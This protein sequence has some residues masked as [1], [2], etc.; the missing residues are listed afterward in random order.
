MSMKKTT[1]REGRG[2]EASAVKE[3]KRRWSAVDTLVVLAL[4]LAVAGVIVRAVMNDREEAAQTYDGPFDV[5][6]TVPEI[7]ESVLSE[8]HGFDMLYL[9]ETGEKMGY[10]GKYDDGSVALTATGVLPVA[11]GETVSAQGCFVCLEGTL[12]DGG[13][14]P[15]GAT[16]YLA[17]GSVLTLRTERAV[18]TLE[19]TEIVLRD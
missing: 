16:R 10:I 1:K 12:S 4:V 17:P 2:S 5:Y 11:G 13:L 15:A 8:I 3:K 9:T 19:I 7:H 14:L 18:V 6:F